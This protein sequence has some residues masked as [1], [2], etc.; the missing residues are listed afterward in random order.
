[1]FLLQTNKKQGFF[2][3]VLTYALGFLLLITLSSILGYELSFQQHIMITLI[4]F[5]LT[6]SLC[7]NRYT[8]F[9]CIG[10][11][12]LLYL[13]QYYYF[14]QAI[15]LYLNNLIISIMD[16]FSSRVVPTYFHP[17][18]FALIAFMVYIIFYFIRL[19][20]QVHPLLY[21][22][23][24]GIL[25]GFEYFIPLMEY[26]YFL[27]FI[28]MALLALALHKQKSIGTHFF[29]RSFG[30][31]TCFAVGIFI[32][33]GV[34]KLPLWFD[35]PKNL[36]FTLG[37][38]IENMSFF[39][40]TVEAPVEY[41]PQSSL[42]Q[43]TF[44]DNT[45]VMNVTAK[46]PHY[47]R[48]LIMDD[49]TGN[50]WTLYEDQTLVEPPIALDQTRKG[51]PYL[52]ALSQGKRVE[53]LSQYYHTSFKSDLLPTESFDLTI[54]LQNIST[55]YFFLPYWPVAPIPFA[56]VAGPS[57]NLS[58]SKTGMLSSD[59]PLGKD[60][61]YIIKGEQI[62]HNEHIVYRALK[63]SYVGLDDTLQKV[64]AYDYTG[65]GTWPNFTGPTTAEMPERIYQLARDLTAS[66]DDDID[67]VL[68]I[69][70]YLASQHTYTLEPPET[71]KDRNMVDYFLFDSKEGFCTYYATAMTIM[72][73]SIG[74]PARYVRG[75]KM[76]AKDT[77]PGEEF[78][79]KQGE[80]L[81]DE[82]QVFSVRQRNA[83]AWVEV[84]FQG[85]GWVA[86]EPTSAFYEEPTYTTKPPEVTPASNPL[87]PVNKPPQP[88]VFKLKNIVS[89]PYFGAVMIWSLILTLLGLA[90]FSPLKAWHRYKRF[91]P[92]ESFTY[93]YL[94]V[95]Y[96]LEQLGHERSPHHTLS[97]YARQ[98]RRESYLHQYIDFEP[99]TLAYEGLLYGKDDISDDHLEKIIEGQKTLLQCLRWRKKY[100]AYLNYFIESYKR[101]I[102]TFPRH[103][104][105]TKQGK[106]S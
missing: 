55:K 56:K 86:F 73:R 35:Q 76:P 18:L 36:V 32:A 83:H 64:T 105:K 23:P 72:V 9:M 38:S 6:L 49:F 48:A 78:F 67:K 94:S 90:L 82:Q 16:S 70:S 20:L 17:T 52:L 63:E 34:H 59:I 10:L 47:L 42:Q 60:S 29:W 97:A 2:Q 75:Y 96:L 1:M 71:P 37:T 62:L 41:R 8:F 33:T 30:F 98:L 65:D 101:I 13:L 69:E 77:G 21:L 85:F 51:F 14:G 88:E 58:A 57:A 5:F 80:P 7:Y 89:N 31:I 74:L 79:I 26:R 95:L 50:S 40:E 24:W 53:D 44:N 43:H 99:L 102:K 106:A 61:T 19:R 87:P 91:T 12:I 46:K 11:I 54:D 4:A 100:F 25:Y 93:H 45:L 27:Y 68:A 103:D 28:P 3:Y 15:T 92:R 66:Y 81:P 84:Y 39:G 104:A 22:V